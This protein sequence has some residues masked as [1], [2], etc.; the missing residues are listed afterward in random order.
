MLDKIRKTWGRA[1]FT[2]IELLVVIA[3]I[4]LLASLLLPALTKARDMA[5]SVKCMSNLKQCGLAFQMYADDWDGY[6]CAN[7]GEVHGGSG[8]EDTWSYYLTGQA[9]GCTAEYVKTG[10]VLC[11]SYKPR[12]YDNSDDNRRLKTYA[13]FSRNSFHKLDKIPTMLSKS[14]AQPSMSEIILLVD[15]MDS[16][17]AELK[18]IFNGYANDAAA[19]VHCRHNKRANCLFADGHVDSLSKDDLIANFA[20][21]AFYRSPDDY[22][23]NIMPPVA[24]YIIEAD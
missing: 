22:G 4:A 17:P 9:A 7:S 5:R 24:A 23:D 13:S 18:Q 12:Q 6:L 19:C 14:G 15:S 20:K 10:V 2:L 11:P 21:C 1:A 16:R 8:S 3:I